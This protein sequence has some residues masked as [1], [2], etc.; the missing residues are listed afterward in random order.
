MEKARKVRGREQGEVEDGTGKRRRRKLREAMR[1]ASSVQ[2]QAP[3]ISHVPRVELPES[4]R[5]AL[6]PRG[7]SRGLLEFLDV[8]RLLL[9]SHSSFC[10]EQRVGGEGGQLLE[11][12]RVDAERRQ[13]KRVPPQLDERHHS[14]T[15]KTHQA[16]PFTRPGIVLGVSTFRPPRA[17]SSAGPDACCCCAASTQRN[18]GPQSP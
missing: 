4:R 13:S 15:H 12:V 3:S 5:E 14:P 10:F 17:A 18:H 2:V 8:R 1:S 7:S 6:A 9:L 16:W 11:E